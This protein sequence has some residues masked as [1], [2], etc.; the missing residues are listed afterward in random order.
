M[1]FW[2][3]KSFF[4]GALLTVGLAITG[5]GQASAAMISGT[6]TA[7]N[8]YGLFT[9]NKDGSIL[10][11]IG[12]NE[13]G[14]AGSPGAY[15]WSQ[16]ETWKFNINPGDYLYTVVWDDGAV[17]ESWIGEFNLESGE[18]LLS[19]ASKWEYVV[20]KSKNPGENGDVPL[21]SE[22]TSEIQNA[23]WTGSNALGKNGINPWGFIQEVS[24]DASFLNVSNPNSMNYTIFRTKN[25]VVTKDVPEPVS[26]S[27]LLAFGI[28]G[29]GSFLKR[30]IKES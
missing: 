27:A 3:T 20:S 14:A 17:A 15:N 29:A 8:H 11:F 2:F 30:K 18:K 6:L 9:G 22:L 25:A 7:D 1:M 13:K 5:A 16:A 19:D 26:S 24:A 21:T 10:N 12:R 28:F 23:K 4:T